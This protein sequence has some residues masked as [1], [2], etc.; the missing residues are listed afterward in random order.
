MPIFVKWNELVRTSCVY[1]GQNDAKSM[2]AKL[3]LIGILDFW[4]TLITWTTHQSPLRWNGIERTPHFFWLVHVHRRPLSVPA[5]L[6]PATNNELMI[7]SIQKTSTN[8]CLCPSPNPLTCIKKTHLCVHVASLQFDG[9][10]WWSKALGT[11]RI[12]V[13]SVIWGKFFPPLCYEK[14]K[15]FDFMHQ[16]SLLAIICLADKSW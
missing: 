3:K 6:G 4:R 11:G 10:M 15:I 16:F 5:K 8:S 12:W 13:C 2:E 7:I 9:A 1:I 14:L